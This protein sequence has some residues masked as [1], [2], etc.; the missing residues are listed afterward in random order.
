MFMYSGVKHLHARTP[1][2]IQHTRT[3]AH[4]KMPRKKSQHQSK[5]QDITVWIA[6]WT[7]REDENRQRVD[8]I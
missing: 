8:V 1:S 7:L 5:R 3:H 2:A 6:G 4:S